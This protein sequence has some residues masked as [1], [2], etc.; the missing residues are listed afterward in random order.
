[1]R[2]RGRTGSRAPDGRPLAGIHG[3]AA[4][5]HL[6]PARNG[7]FGV[8]NAAA[9]TKDKRRRGTGAG[10]NLAIQQRLRIGAV[11]L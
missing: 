1:M 8:F 11:T 5:P 2:L 10:F 4:L 6:I 3:D 9:F 7:L